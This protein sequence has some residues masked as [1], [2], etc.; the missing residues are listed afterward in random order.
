LIKNIANEEALIM[1]MFFSQS[2]DKR[3]KSYGKVDELSNF[4]VIFAE[5]ER[6]K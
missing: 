4:G 2:L 3:Q 5:R 1:C 6:E